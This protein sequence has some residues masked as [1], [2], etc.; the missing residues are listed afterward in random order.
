[1]ATRHFGESLFAAAHLA[2]EPFLSAAD[3]GSGAGF[4]GVP[5]AIYIPASKVTLIE[6]QNKKA[7]FLREVARVLELKN[8][9]VA[10]A[11][12]ESIELRSGLV[13]MRAVEKFAESAPAAELLVE[14]GGRLAMLIGSSQVESAKTILPHLEFAE[15]V[16][17][18]QSTG[19]ILL[20]GRKAA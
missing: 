3:V 5:L 12:A 11:R 4:P 6:S 13:T 14:C 8:V 1:M 2:R 10:N 7:T 17:I 20:V 18:P 9:V 16:P 19:R 15:P